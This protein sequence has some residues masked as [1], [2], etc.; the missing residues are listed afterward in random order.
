MFKL[1][2]DRL[3]NATCPGGT[4]D[5]KNTLD[6]L[7][8]L[9]SP[10]RDPPRTIVCAVNHTPLPTC[11]SPGEVKDE[12]A[13]VAGVPETNIVSC[14]R[15]FADITA[16]PISTCFLQR[17][18]MPPSVHRSPILTVASRLNVLIDSPSK[19]FKWTEH[20]RSMNTEPGPSIVT[21][22]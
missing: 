21:S 20:R 10:T 8:T 14:S 9:V 12:S 6:K 2:C 4:R 22:A 19:A 3:P 11:T 1:L 5:W 17:M 18:V 15:Q 7:S 13:A 16:S